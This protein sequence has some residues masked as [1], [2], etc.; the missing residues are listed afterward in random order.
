MFYFQ[1]ISYAL[2]SL[3]M[4]KKSSNVPSILSYLDLNLNIVSKMDVI[5]IKFYCEAICLVG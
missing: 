5:V 4:L 2:F 3:L 1:L